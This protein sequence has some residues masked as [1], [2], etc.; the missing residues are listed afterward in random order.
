MSPSIKYG[1]AGAVAG[2][3][4]IV[5]CT[6][7]WLWFLPPENYLGRVLGMC[8]IAIGICFAQL[9][10]VEEQLRWEAKKREET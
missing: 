7:D 6:W 5:F 1:I 3:L 8:A 9:M 10:C 4:A 2:Y